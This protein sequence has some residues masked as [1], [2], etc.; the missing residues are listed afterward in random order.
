MCGAAMGS[1]L[2]PIMANLFMEE[3]EMKALSNITF[4]PRFYK[5]YVDDSFMIIKKRYTQKM[6]DHLNM[7]DEN[8]KFT[9]ER[10][11]DRELPFLD[12]KTIALPN[13]N[14]EVEVYRKPTHTDQYLNFT[15]E[16]PYQHKVSVMN[17][18]LHRKD[19]LITSEPSKRKEQ[20]HIEKVL[21]LSHY[22]SWA[23]RKAEKCMQKKKEQ[24]QTNDTNLDKPK[25]KGFAVIPYMKNLS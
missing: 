14:I 1:P 4:S 5:R 20:E 24:K 7:Q 12:A 25:G 10:E 11:M 13:G 21:R 17:T 9:I 2:S 18:L 3:L 22:P 6:L 8:V 23:I 16:H 19:H 15:S